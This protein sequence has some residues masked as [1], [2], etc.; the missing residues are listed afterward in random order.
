MHGFGKRLLVVFVV[1]A[2]I[3]ASC[4]ESDPEADGPVDHSDRDQVIEGFGIA[5]FGSDIEGTIDYL[6]PELQGEERAR[7]TSG[8]RDYPEI[9][10]SL[11][12]PD[13]FELR[14]FAFEIVSDA[15]S[16]VE[17]RYSGQRC[18]TEHDGPAV[19]TTLSSDDA[20]PGPEGSV[21]EAGPLVFGCN[22]LSPENP[23]DVRA[24]WEFVEIDGLW[25]ARIP[26]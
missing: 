4:G 6:E 1:L 13:D 26:T 22:D 17:V 7:L 18:G 12:P 2:L 3:G 24:E 9:Y 15:G 25:Y 16:S 8:R 10:E 11:L 19:V 20:Q 21:S 14:D 5:M 23:A